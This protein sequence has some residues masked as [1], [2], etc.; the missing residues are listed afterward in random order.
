MSR[1]LEYMPVLESCA[2]APAPHNPGVV[3]HPGD[4][5]VGTAVQDHLG[6]LETGKGGMDTVLVNTG[7]PK[8]TE[9]SS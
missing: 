7:Q 4:E 6:Q 9:F 8:I 5:A 3:A 2:Q 1:L